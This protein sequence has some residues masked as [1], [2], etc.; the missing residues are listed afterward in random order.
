MLYVFINRVIA[1]ARGNMAKKIL[2][3]CTLYVHVHYE[4]R[5]KD[6]CYI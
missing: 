5:V 1:L 4:W 2:V 3:E 6:I